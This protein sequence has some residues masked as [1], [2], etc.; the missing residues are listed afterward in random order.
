MYNYKNNFLLV[1][2]KDHF[3]MIDKVHIY[4]TRY[5]KTNVFLPR[6][7]RDC[8]HKSLAY[9]VS[10]LWNEI[11]NNLKDQSHLGNFQVKLEDILLNHQL[12][13]YSIN[14][15]HVNTIFSYFS[16]IL[17]I[18]L[19]LRMVIIEFIGFLRHWSSL[20]FSNFY[21]V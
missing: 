21:Y 17:V 6:F 10:R 15:L 7:H 2:F 16:S 14:K 4:L 12:K 5:S 8:D 11:H 18:T 13:Q 9:Q 1:N 19:Y 20:D 3:K